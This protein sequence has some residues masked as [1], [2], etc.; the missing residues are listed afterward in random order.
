MSNLIHIGQSGLAA[1]RGH[2]NVA[3]H[4]ISN[5]H[6]PGF[7]RQQAL[8]AS[9]GEMGTSMGSG[10]RLTDI[11]RHYNEY[12]TCA[13]RSSTSLATEAS[14]Y[15]AQ[16]SA[17]DGLLADAPSSISGG[18]QQFFSALQA[19]SKNPA[20]L[21]ER[22][23]ILSEAEALARR[24]NAID[25]QLAEQ[26]KQCH[27]QMRDVAGEIN[28]LST[29]IAALNQ[30]IA[31]S[32]EA[33]PDLLDARDEALRQL[34]GF[35]GISTVKQDNGS[36]NVLT[37]SGAPLVL[38]HQAN[39]LEVVPAQGDPQR[40]EVHLLEGGERRNIGG[41]ISGGELGGLIRHS[42]EALEPARRAIGRM[43]LVLGQEVNRQLAAGLNLNGEAGKGLFAD[44]NTQE[45]AELR[46]KA[47]ASNS[48]ARPQL[49]IQDARLLGTQDVQL[50]FDGSRYRARLEDGTPLNVTINAAGDLTFTDAE[51]RDLGFT[52]APGFPPPAAGDRFTL[53]P[54]ARGAA[55][56]N[57]C[58]KN[59]AELALAA[60]LRSQA[61][62]GNKGSA[63]ISAPELLSRLD[64]PELSSHLPLTLRWNEQ[65][66]GFDLP[67][68]AK[69]SRIN[70][71][72]FQDGQENR[73]ELQLSD[74]SR[75]Q[76]SLSGHPKNGDKFEIAINQ[77]GIKDNRNA[78]KLADLQKKSI[79]GV[80]SR[81]PDSGAS[82]AGSYG[83]LLMQVGSKTAQ[84]RQDHEACGLILQQTTNNRNSV[85]AVDIDEEGAN[86]L[87][88]QQHYAAA[89]Q[90]IQVA[91]DLFDSLLASLR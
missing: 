75:L 29:Q 86:L 45:L 16:I 57:A 89:A 83:E 53:Q 6:T 12:L 69:L 9:R 66:K 26:A 31:S 20:G 47:H 46:V 14:T 49:H 90:V 52:V 58:L 50:E 30:S 19:A 72:D 4:N 73:Y 28:R 40:F 91:R 2:L 5:A 43:A 80:D 35:I 71:G 10:T 39:Q 18:L 3:G 38:G 41:Q 8:Q 82:L 32:G 64:L 60:P 78:L 37:A 33:S 11:R 51:G 87:R 67:A 27:Q 74:G 22:Q 21:P 59:P 70:P 54:T 61:D 68:G 65:A 1:S 7:S 23:G 25:S 76:F 79:V 17:I 84:A 24:F 81:R 77:G 42:L 34:S 44:C 55:D 56:I 13:Q 48:A 15:L 36:V 85:S 88:Y 63:S 62:E